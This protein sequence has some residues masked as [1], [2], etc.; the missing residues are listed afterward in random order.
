MRRGIIERLL[1]PIALLTWVLLFSI[2]AVLITE[3]LPIFR[4]VPLFH[5]ILGQN[6]YPVDEPPEFG[7]LPLILGSFLIT[8]G[9]LTVSL[10]LGLGCAIYLSEIAPSRVRES[11]KPFIEM[12]SGIPSVIYGFFGLVFLSPLIQRLFQIPVGLTGLTAA[13]ILGIMALPTIASIAEDAITAVPQSIREASLALGATKWETITKV[14]IPAARSGI[15]T[16]II[17][18]SGRMI[19]ETMTV[20]MVAGGAAVIPKSLLEPV[21]T[22]TAT[23]AAEMGETPMGSP[24]YHALFGIGL[25]LFLVTLS[26]SVL[27][28]RIRR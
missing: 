22:M 18:G 28:E 5:F 25:I 24:H 14:V 2:V 12:L 9:A 11:I 3:S 4:K 6:W 27:A 1:L 7:I 16:A 15:I 20:L 23:I 17:L 10:P 8:V 21:R 26:L 19:G 13:I